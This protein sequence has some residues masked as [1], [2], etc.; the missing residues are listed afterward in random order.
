M[1]LSFSGDGSRP[2]ICRCKNQKFHRHGN[3]FR[4]IARVFVYRFRCAS[5][6]LTIS[7]LP[8]MCVPYK[9]YPVGIINPV[10]DGMFLQDRS[11]HYYERIAPQGI[12]ASTAHRWRNEFEQHSSTLATEAAHRLNIAALLGTGARVYRHLKKHFSD[13]YADF[14]GPLQ[15]ALCRRFPP[16]GIFRVL[17]S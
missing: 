2:S 1:I 11:G 9:R 8:S 17:H 16:L 5:C 12:H 15:L 13:Q 3:Y 14:F 4:A 7:M 10:L 6:L